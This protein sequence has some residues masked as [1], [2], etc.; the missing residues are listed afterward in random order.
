MIYRIGDRRVEL[1]GSEHFVAHNATVVGSVVLEDRVNVWFNAVVRGD[2]ERIVIG[3]G[4]NIQDGCVLHAD[5]GV[6]LHIGRYVTVGHKVMLHGCTIGDDTLIGINA[7]ILN[8]ARI[9]RNCIVGAN[10]LIPEGKE[11]PDGS[12][13]VG[14]PGQVKR[15]L[16]PDEIAALREPA[17]HYVQNARHYR[18]A[19]EP[20][21][22]AGAPTPP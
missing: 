11:I 14:T 15:R 2:A 8:N 1:R 19:F 5:P 16:S 21:E 10:A 7:V 6:P 3:E 4:T 22:R 9:G 12:L 17:E 13:V 18:E 20:D